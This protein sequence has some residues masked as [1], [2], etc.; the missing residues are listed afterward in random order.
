MK[1]KLLIFKL[2]NPY[3]TFILSSLFFLSNK[4][5]KSIKRN[6]RQRDREKE[7]ESE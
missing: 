1:I 7:S 3:S 4:R 2:D 6:T 5:R